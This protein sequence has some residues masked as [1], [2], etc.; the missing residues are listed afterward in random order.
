MR[1]RAGWP[2][3]T[4]ALILTA[5]CTADAPDGGENGTESAPPVPRVAV[6][7][8]SSPI[9]NEPESRRDVTM[10]GC[11]KVDGGWEARGA[12]LNSGTKAATYT[13]TVSFTSSESTVLARDATQVKV[14]AGKRK[15]WTSTARFKAPN[16][17]VCVLRGVGR[18]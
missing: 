7:P 13:I 17:T 5:A 15:A 3:M 10:S 11:S 16:P 1:P 9:V 18:A 6:T 4:A 8:S 14:A 2:L 12:I